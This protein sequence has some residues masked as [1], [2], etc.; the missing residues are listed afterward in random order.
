[1]KTSCVS[2]PFPGGIASPEKQIPRII[3]SPIVR[4]IPLL[5]A[6][7]P[8]ALILVIPEILN[9]SKVLLTAHS[10]IHILY[11]NT[12]LDMLVNL[13]KQL[14]LKLNSDNI[15]LDSIDELINKAII[16]L[17]G[18]KVWLNSYS[19]KLK[20]IPFPEAL[21]LNHSGF[22]Y[23]TGGNYLL[24]NV[25]KLAKKKL[26]PT[27]D[28]LFHLTLPFYLKENDEPVWLDR[29][30]TLDVIKWVIE[31]INNNPKYKIKNQ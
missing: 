21:R 26:R 31:D 30:D 14:P 25:H 22:H 13:L 16:A 7:P 27:Q 23:Y 4:D 9:N 2:T 20:E 28:R 12:R 6:D 3:F 29:D 11:S 5:C 1:M 19:E 8:D 18:Y 17:D 10:K 24:P 15:T